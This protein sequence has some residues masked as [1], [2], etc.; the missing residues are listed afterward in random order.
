M[1]RST[2][3]DE[4]EALLVVATHESRAGYGYKSLPPPTVAFEANQ[5]LQYF[6]PTCSGNCGIILEAL[7]YSEHACNQW[8]VSDPPQSNSTTG[9]LLS[10]SG[11]HCE[12]NH[13]LRGTW[14]RQPF[15]RRRIAL[16]ILT[17]TGY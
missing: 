10:S 17:S 5:R 8:S 11:H 15:S 6:V 16:V 14:Q 13:D 7:M 2:S 9:E 4:D 1:N 12:M 3:D